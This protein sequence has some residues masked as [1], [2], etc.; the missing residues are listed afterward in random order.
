MAECH[1]CSL[2]GMSLLFAN[3]HC[4]RTRYSIYPKPNATVPMILIRGIQSWQHLRDCNATCISFQD[5]HWSY[6]SSIV[7]YKG[8]W[9]AALWVACLEMIYATAFKHYAP[10]IYCSPSG[11]SWWFVVSSHYFIHP[12]TSFLEIYSLWLSLGSR[13]S[14]SS[15]L[16]ITL[17][18]DQPFSSCCVTCL[19]SKSSIR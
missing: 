3:S 19:S 2:H 4:C 10:P 16:S 1:S 8:T 9:S 7:I 17:T 11:Y 6:P 12:P 15:T 18:L 5:D 13:C 14:C